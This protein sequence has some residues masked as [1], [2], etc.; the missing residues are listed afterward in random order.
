MELR[1]TAKPE[2]QQT[3]LADIGYGKIFK[4]YS[5]SDKFYMKLKNNNGLLQ[6]TYKDSGFLVDIETGEVFRA[7]LNSHIIPIDVIG[8]IKNV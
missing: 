6:T 8:E 2:P 4:I 1:R 7:A 5:Y 3:T